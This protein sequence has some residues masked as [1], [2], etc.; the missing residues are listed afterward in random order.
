[1][2]TA[3]WISIRS[4]YLDPEI[5][6]DAAEVKLTTELEGFSKSLQTTMEK[7]P[8]TKPFFLFARTGVNGLAMAGKHTP[9]INLLL[10]KQRAI[11]T[12]SADNLGPVM[13]YG[14][15]TAEQLANAK[16]LALGR[17]T[18]GASVIFMAAQMHMNG[19]L[20]GSGPVIVSCVRLGKTMVISVTTVKLGETGFL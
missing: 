15:Q 5:F 16:A 11:F 4:K 8:W 19:N 6:A 9:G 17:Q 3:L 1:M 20:R 2:L 13:K 18:M 7:S 14:I 12:A 10:S